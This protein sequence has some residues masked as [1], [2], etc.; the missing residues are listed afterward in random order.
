MSSNFKAVL[1]GLALLSVLV[2]VGVIVANR[3][4][5]VPETRYRG[6]GGEASYN[7]YLALSLMLERCG[8]DVERMA[9]LPSRDQL[10]ASDGTVFLPGTRATYS[11]QRY[12]E[13]L[14][15]AEAGGH[16]VVAPEYF[17]SPFAFLDDDPE[18]NRRD[19]LLDRIEVGVRTFEDEVE[20][21]EEFDEYD[22]DDYV[23]SSEIPFQL[24]DSDTS[25]RASIPSRLEVLGKRAHWTI[26]AEDSARLVHRKIGKGGVTV[27]ADNHW[28]TNVTIGDYEHATLAHFLA[29]L[30]GR[31]GEVW[32]VYGA[33]VPGLME[34]AFQ[35][36]WPILL[37][38]AVALALW[39]AA[40]A[41]SFGA[42]HP[43]RENVRRSVME[44]IEAIG[45]F[46]W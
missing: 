46:L 33:D 43:V 10:P 9:R 26:G 3:L 20:D 23:D 31:A 4:E 21:S 1:P 15:W 12:E 30:G 18:E 5:K 36:G 25:V 17:E 16:L 41:T 39:L 24:P 2:A 14:V 19:P 11:Q 35:Y 8:L 27:I 22:Y 40:R 37:A 45:A 44:H 28:L 7:P 34:M 6:Y 29:T 38:A 13:L 42:R 32:V